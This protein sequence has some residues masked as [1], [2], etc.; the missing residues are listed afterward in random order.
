MGRD[1][2][3]GAPA[4]L[5]ASDDKFM[6]KLCQPAWDMTDAIFGSTPPESCDVDSSSYVVSGGECKLFDDLSAFTA[7]MNDEGVVDDSGFRLTFNGVKETNEGGKVIIDFAC[8]EEDT[9][10]GAI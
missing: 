5:E 1:K 4:I 6:Y 8:E 9:T 7:H 2:T 10:D 3:T